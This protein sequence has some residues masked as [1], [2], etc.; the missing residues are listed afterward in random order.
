M[1]ILCNQETALLITKGQVVHYTPFLPLKKKVPFSI[2]PSTRREKKTFFFF[3]LKEIKFHLHV[4]K[5]EQC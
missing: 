2:L 4:D 5:R 3:F 1:I